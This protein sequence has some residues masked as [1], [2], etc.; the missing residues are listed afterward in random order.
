MEILPYKIAKACTEALKNLQTATISHAETQ[1]EGIG[2]N[3][4]YDV[5]APPLVDVLK[6]TWRPAKPELTDTTCHVI[7]VQA[8]GIIIGFLSYFGCHPVVCCAPSRYVHGDFPA[9]AT[10]N[11]EREIPGAIG[12]FL[13]GA[14]GDVNSCV[15]HKTEQ[16]SLL[17]LDIIA[18]RYA[19]AVRKGI[20]DANAL[21]ITGISSAIVEKNFTEMPIP[22]QELKNMLA[23]KEKLVHRHDADDSDSGLRMATVYIQTLKK[24]IDLV[25]KGKPTYPKVK[26]Q[27]LK[28][29]PIALLGAPFEI[30]QAIKNDVKASAKSKIPLVMGLTNECLGYAPDK[31][32]A[33]GYAAKIVPMILGHMPFK[34]IHEELVETLLELDGR[35]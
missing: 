23:E 1:C 33:E 34:K 14:Q 16:E 19:N 4:Q 9:I 3:R 21:K 22:L 26:I 2:L 18:G 10:N 27:G 13:Q 5:D 25:S 15:V 29:G 28:I 35:L 12:L 6:D 31:Q 32:T 17:A 24:N 11:L 7:K 30:F 20:A 8:K